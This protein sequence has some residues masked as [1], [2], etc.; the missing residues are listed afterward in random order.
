M[1]AV[2]TSGSGFALS[3]DAFQEL[4]NGEGVAK[5]TVEVSYE[6]VDGWHCGV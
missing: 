2:D 4:T 1:L 6:Q 5:G 3:R